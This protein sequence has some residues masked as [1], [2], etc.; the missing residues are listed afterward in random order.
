MNKDIKNKASKENSTQRRGL[1]KSAVIVGGVVGVAGSLP[2]KWTTPVIDM[3]T[4]PAHAQTS[5][6]TVRQWASEATGSDEYNESPGEWSFVQATGAPNTFVCGD[7]ETAHAYEDSNGIRFLQLHFNTPVVPSEVNIYISYAPGQITSVELYL[8]E[9][10]VV[11]VPNS[12]HN[13]SYE[14]CDDENESPI[15]FS[16]DVTGLTTMCVDS[17]LLRVDQ[18]IH[19]EYHEV[20]AVELVGTLAC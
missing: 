11:V 2:S 7:I 13:V 8:G 4:T 17:V 20:D 9:N 5:A 6:A 3:V 16:P 18:D 19:E 15:V 14:A 1:I 12:S 10:L